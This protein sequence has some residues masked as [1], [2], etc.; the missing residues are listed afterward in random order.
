MLLPGRQVRPS[1]RLCVGGQQGPCPRRPEEPQSVREMVPAGPWLLEK[2][3]WEG[4]PERIRSPGARRF[5]TREEGVLVV[6]V[7]EAERSGRKAEGPTPA[8][9]R[10]AALPRASPGGRVSAPKP[11]PAASLLLPGK[12]GP[13]V[14]PV[15]GSAVRQTAAAQSHP[16]PAWTWL[17][18][19]ETQ[20]RMATPPHSS[21]VTSTS[22]LRPT[23]AEAPWADALSCAASFDGWKS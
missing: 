17:P 1:V 4:E 23:W 14:H 15:P 21:S 12:P 9:W 20:R 19:K 13:E 18:L 16:R 8:T 6:G 10:Q 11:G 5:L 22:A 7:C 2:G 3:K